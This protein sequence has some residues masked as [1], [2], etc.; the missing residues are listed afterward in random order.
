LV[1]LVGLFVAWRLNSRLHYLDPSDEILKEVFFGRD[2]WIVLCSNGTTV[3]PVFEGTSRKHQS[4]SFGVLDCAAPLPSKKTTYERLKLNTYVTGPVIFF[5]GFGNDPK[6]LSPKLLRNQYS[7]VREITALTNVHASKVKESSSLYRKCLKKG[8]CGVVFVGGELDKAAVKAVNTIADATPNFSW[9]LVDSTKHKL[10]KPSEK[11]LGVRKFVP[12]AHRL[13][14]LGQA[15]DANSTVLPAV[16]F[17]GSFVEDELEKF[18]LHF[19]E[20]SG[21]IE[22]KTLDSEEVKLMKRKPPTNYRGLCLLVCCRSRYLSTLTHSLHFVV[23][24]A[25]VAS[26]TINPEATILPTIQQEEQRKLIAARRAQREAERRA[27]M[28]AEAED[29]IEYEGEEDSLENTPTSDNEDD[30][31]DEGAEEEDDDEEEYVDL[32]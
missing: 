28:D 15:S 27:E 30:E 7:L 11:E 12:G 5:S 32:D 4:V 19:V 22:R 24:S 29:F 17:L 25:P 23:N 8:N 21:S 16:P 13:L 1:A 10:R 31:D 3:D 9:V 18:V 6:Q 2:P 14:L 20:N 26:P